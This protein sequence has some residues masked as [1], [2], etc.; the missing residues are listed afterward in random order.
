VRVIAVH[1]TSAYNNWLK[2][3]A[4]VEEENVTHAGRYYIMHREYRVPYTHAAAIHKCKWD[5]HVLRYCWDANSIL[6]SVLLTSFIFGLCILSQ[7]PQVKLSNISV[8]LRQ[9]WGKS[10]LLSCMSMYIIHKMFNKCV[11]FINRMEFILWQEGEKQ[12]FRLNRKLMM[13]LCKNWRSWLRHY[14]TSR[15]VADSIPDGV[16]GNFIAIPLPAALWPWCWL[17]LWQKWVSGI[18]P[19]G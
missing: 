6:P 17:S 7:I 19:E 18:I 16:T 4:A 3:D 8:S 9:G 12:R 14:A 15:K 13:P 11:L 5:A 2:P 1:T 10:Y